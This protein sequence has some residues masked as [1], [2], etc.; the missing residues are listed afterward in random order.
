MMMG[1]NIKM[2]SGRQCYGL[3]DENLQFAQMA[4]LFWP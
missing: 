1:G 3:C 2:V 4:F